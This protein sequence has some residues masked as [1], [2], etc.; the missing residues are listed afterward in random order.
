MN[1]NI[2][3]IKPV[4][5]NRKAGT[6]FFL[7]VCY[8]IVEYMRPAFLAPIRPAVIIQVVLFFYLLGNKEKIGQIFNERYYRL[9]A[10]LLIYMFFHIFFATNNYWALMH[11]QY[12]ITYLL[13]GIS[14]CVYL[15]TFEKLSSFLRYFTIIMALCAVDRIAG[16]GIIGRDGPMGDENDFALAMNTILPIS[17]FIGK[18]EQGKWR[19][20]FIACSILFVLG[21]MVSESRGGFIGMATVGIGCMAF[22]KHK[23]K[24]AMGIAIAGIIAFSFASQ[25]FI[26]E[27]SG[28]GLE[29]ADQDTG[30]E[31][32]EL[33]KIGWRA[34]L[35]N[36][37]FGVGQGNMPIVMEK[38]QY[39]EFGISYWHRGLWG[40]AIHSVYFTVLPETGIV[41]S[42]IVFLMLRDLFVKMRDIRTFC[43]RG[44]DR[45]SESP[46]YSL[47]AGL[48]V[49]V[50]ALLVTGVFLSSFYYAQFWNLPALIIALFMT[51]VRT[52]TS[53]LPVSPK[54]I[55]TPREI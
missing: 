33:W 49:S 36:P 39:D 51:T 31:R 10:L 53:E 4:V 42:I 6:P 11:F 2:E 17:F 12:L 55:E 41:G 30:K 15:D 34:F 1:E 28:I 37:V 54:Q 19:W 52:E 23:M 48:M 14:C 13:I 18:T 24:A 43:S 40:R 32:I 21:N 7:L 44:D 22:S 27:I 47:N 3:T 25:T 20:L 45:G 46:I 5:E 26:E 38:Y 35:D 50:I 29:S 16:I 9:Y 8:L